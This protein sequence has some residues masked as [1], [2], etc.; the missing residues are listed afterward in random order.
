[1]VSDERTE[2][3]ERVP[4]ETLPQ[5]V[6]RYEIDR[7]TIT[8]RATNGPFN[9]AFDTDIAPLTLAAWWDE[10]GLVASERDL[11]AIHAAIHAGDT[12]ETVVFVPSEG[13]TEET[14]HRLCAVPDGAPTTGTLTLIKTQYQTD[15]QSVSEHIASVVSHDLRN[16]LDVAKARARAARETGD[17]EHFDRLDRAHD[18]MER[19]IGDVLTFARGRGAVDATPGVAI[20][21]ISEEAWRAVET[22]NASLSVAPDLSTVEAD[23]DHLQRLFENLFR[24]AVEHGAVDQSSRAESSETADHDPDT[25]VTVR[26]KPADD[27]FAVT[28]DGPGIPPAE[29]TR[30]FEPGYSTDSDGTGLGLTIVDQIADAHGWTVTAMKSESGGTRFKITGLAEQSS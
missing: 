7:D 8:L 22:G 9:S 13:A 30:V 2:T 15:G 4:V 26:V 19:I 16:P 21:D 17:T 5:A 24:N 6:A 18:R 12:V 27:G 29:R 3:G 23:P 14:P 1:M 10:N 11:G 20:A 28:D 25:A